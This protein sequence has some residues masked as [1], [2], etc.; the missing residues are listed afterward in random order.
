MAE[1]VQD[2]EGMRP[3]GANEERTISRDEGPRLKAGVTPWF[4]VCITR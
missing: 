2:V 3:S 4:A 1:A